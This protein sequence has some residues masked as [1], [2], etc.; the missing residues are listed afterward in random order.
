MVI[1]HLT[2]FVLPT[3]V[4]CGGRGGSLRVSQAGGSNANLTIA[5]NKKTSKSKVMLFVYAKQQ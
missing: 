3:N 5:N 4:L 1:K 2:V